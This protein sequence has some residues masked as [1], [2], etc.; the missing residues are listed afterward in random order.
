MDK[1]TFNGKKIKE[2]REKSKIPQTSFAKQIGISQSFLSQI[3]N[4]T[5]MP[6]LDITKKIAD[7][8]QVSVDELLVHEDTDSNNIAMGYD[9]EDFIAIIAGQNEKIRQYE[10]QHRVMQEQI[11]T[12]IAANGNLASVVGKNAGNQ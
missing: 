10:E 6:S 9:Y 2:L 8:L 5:R 12:L 11:N 3:E 1:I 4:S 7:C